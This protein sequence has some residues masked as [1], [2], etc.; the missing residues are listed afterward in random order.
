MFAQMDP[1]AEAFFLR[2]AQEKGDGIRS[3]RRH[4]ASL[5]L[6]DK[7]KTLDN[8]DQ[9]AAQAAKWYD[10]FF[11]LDHVGDFRQM[12]LMMGIEIEDDPYNKEP[13][14][15]ELMMGRRVCLKAREK[16]LIIRPLG[17]VVVLMPPLCVSEE[18]LDRMMGIT[19]ESIR[20]V[21]E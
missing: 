16:G 12:G 21:T 18:E 5:H 10:R 4:R 19:L 15:P 14:A 17:D 7:D 11:K 8:V 6:F 3:M 1:E 20:E 2:R 9:R 13:Y